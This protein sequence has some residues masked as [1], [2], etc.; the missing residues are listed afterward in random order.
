MTAVE[1]QRGNLP[2]LFT[3]FVGRRSE[4]AA[5]RGLLQ[6]ARLV[7]LTGPGGVGKTRLALEAAD[8]SA[9]TFPDGVWLVELA[10]VQDPAAVAG[11]IATALGM[12]DRGTAPVLEQLEKYLAQRRALIV[13]DNCEH[14][15]DACAVLAKTLLCAAPE[16]HIL[17]TSRRTLGITGEQLFTVSPLGAEDAAGLLEDRA[18]AVRSGFEVGERNRAE[19]ARLCSD[20]DGLPLAIELAASRLRTLTVEQVAQRLEDRFGLLTGGSSTALPHQRTLRQTIAWSY[21]LC[22]PAE[23]LLWNRLSIFAGGF[24][25]DAAEGVCS[26]DGIAEGEVLDLLD[27]LVGQSVVLTTEVEGV[28][29]YRLLESVRQYGREQLAAS[30]E[31]E[32]FLGRRRDFFVGVAQRIDAGWYGSGQVQ[33]LA[34]LRAD[35]TNLLAALDYDADPQARL[36]LAGA[37]IFHW[38]VGGFLLE[39]RRQLERALEETP[40]TTRQ[41]ARGLFAAVW[42][43]QTQGDLLAADRWLDEAEELAEQLGDPVGRARAGGFR[44][45][46]ALYREQPEESIC[47]YEG[48]LAASTAAG[49]E[50]EATSW[51]LALA[52]VQAYAGDPRAA[53]SCRQVIAAFEVSGERWGRAQVLMALSHNAWVR[54]DKEAAEA[55]VRSALE[56]MRGFNDH[57]MV[58]RMLELLAWATG[59]GGDHARAARLLGAAGALWRN[60]GTCIAAF[61]PWVAKQHTRCEKAAT[62]A[63]GPGPYAQALEEGASHDNPGQ[64]IKYA[65]ALACTSF[66][67]TA[68]TAALTRRESEVAELVAKGLSNRQIASKLGRSPRTVEG[69]VENLLAKLAFSSRAQIASWWTATHTPASGT[70]EQ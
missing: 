26:G 47:R 43:A 57:A 11:A 54:G 21:E 45:V 31:E 40:E 22:A 63:L 29:R 53:E 15:A 27:Q 36:A 5:I 70:T 59:S 64:A 50:R 69:H 49:D 24:A 32:R 25:L 48:A 13:L 60:A 44:G 20:L 8:I 68:P 61:G 9:K 51:R 39:G 6:S 58:A 30:G 66:T 28:L 35:H 10:P 17:A 12:S 46:S 56:S 19:V 67:P 1:S 62:C 4:V 34:R 3:S 14:L 65:L 38:C 42:V 41:R 55:L 37:L 7:T 18:S 2:A 23:R 33:A 16:L 52:C